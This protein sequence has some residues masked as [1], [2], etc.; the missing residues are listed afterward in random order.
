MKFSQSLAFTSILLSPAIAFAPAS[1]PRATRSVSNPQHFAT[2]EA[3]EA[4][5]T[6]ETG[7]PPKEELFDTDIPEE[8]IIARIGITQEELAIGVNAADFLKYAGT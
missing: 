7:S 6:S 1:Y 5:G 4:E 8:E 2:A 3:T